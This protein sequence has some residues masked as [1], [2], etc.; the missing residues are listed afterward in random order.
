V[1]AAD[2]IAPRLDKLLAG[3]NRADFVDSEDYLVIAG[4][5]NESGLHNEYCIRATAL[6]AIDHGHRVTVVS[7]VHA[8]YDGGMPAA[9]IS[10][11]VEAELQ[12]PGVTVSPN[13]WP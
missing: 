11:G 2:I 13:P 6:E 10:A 1:P 5:H 12:A 4:M 3:T 7:D 8:T 9:E